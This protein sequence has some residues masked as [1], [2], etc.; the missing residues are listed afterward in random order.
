MQ[1]GM[2]Y[3]EQEHAVDELHMLDHDLDQ[4]ELG[5]GLED[6]G[7]PDLWSDNDCTLDDVEWYPDRVVLGNLSV[8]NVPSHDFK[9]IFFELTHHGCEMMA[10]QEESVTKVSCGVPQI[11]LNVAGFMAQH[12]GMASV[13]DAYAG[14]G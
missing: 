4:T 8:F 13:H 6:S 3:T 10:F 9:N 1:T 2:L 14:T 12:A 7:E 11:E 5:F